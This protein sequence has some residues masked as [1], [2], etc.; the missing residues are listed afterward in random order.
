MTTTLTPD[1]TAELDDWPDRFPSADFGAI[2]ME[3]YLEIVRYNLFTHPE[4]AQF[5][6][7][8]EVDLREPRIKR[9][10][11]KVRQE[12]RWGGRA[13]DARRRVRGRWLGR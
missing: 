3:D 8:I 9:A 2:P 1:Q 11:H 6:R 12:L 10:R 5:L 4:V 7:V 13:R